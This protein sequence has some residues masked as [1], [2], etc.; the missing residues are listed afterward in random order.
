MAIAIATL[1][2]GANAAHDQI[3][4]SPKNT[5]FQFSG[6]FTLF[7]D[8][9]PLECHV[10]FTGMTSG[11]G[12]KLHAGSFTGGGAS[13]SG[14]KHVVFSNFPYP[15]SLF[16][17]KIGNIADVRYMFEG[18]TCFTGVAFTLSKGGLWRVADPNFCGMT[19]KAKTNPLITAAKDQP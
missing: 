15:I 1:A 6:D 2:T 18:K 14:C 12:D 16:S 13:G 10:T 5:G 4:L 19:G 8:T 3:Y 11:G 9:T 7:N 17:Q